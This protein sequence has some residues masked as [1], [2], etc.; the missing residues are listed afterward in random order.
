MIERQF[1]ISLLSI[2]ILLLPLRV[3]GQEAIIQQ[4][5]SG[6]LMLS[7]NLNGVPSTGSGGNQ[8][9]AIDAST[10]NVSVLASNDSGILDLTFSQT[11]PVVAYAENDGIHILNTTT[12]VDN[13]LPRTT[14]SG[15]NY[16]LALSADNNQLIRYTYQLPSPNHVIEIIDVGTSMSEVLWTFDDRSLLTQLPIPSILTEAS[17]QDINSIGWNPVYQD[18]LLVQ[19]DITSPEVTSDGHQTIL[20]PIYI[21]NRATSQSIVL[22]DILG[23]PLSAV[24]VKWS[25]DGTRIVLRQ[26]VIQEGRMH[27]ATTIL[28]FE[29]VNGSVTV[30]ELH[31]AA[32]DLAFFDWLGVDDLLL[33]STWDSDTRDVHFLIAQIIGDQYFSSEMLVIPSADVPVVRNRGWHLTAD[34]PERYALSCIFNQ[35]LPTRLE[36][37]SPAQGINNGVPLHLRAEPDLNSIEFL[38]IPEGEEFIIIDGP[39]CVNGTDY[40]RF[41]QLQ[42]NDGTVGWAAEASTNSYFLEPLPET[43]LSTSDF[44]GVASLYGI[45]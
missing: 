27:T 28:S 30:S 36:T 40:R 12:L 32:D 2:V 43:G 42:L 17:F 9:L 37:G 4:P 1:W 7:G 15:L 26:D 22:N 38:Q 11:A 25:P 29:V 3:Q 21:Y 20:S 45:R 18:W 44:I 31:S 33:T 16:P 13:F 34:L 24:P 8:L 5:V 10:G 19:I 23:L 39:A 14:M 41:W 35:A 6:M